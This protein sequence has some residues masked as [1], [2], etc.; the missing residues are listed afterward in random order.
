M[1]RILVRLAGGVLSLGGATLAADVHLGFRG[2]VMTIADAC[3]GV[4][5]AIIYVAAV[6][7]FPGRWRDRILGV[8]IGLPVIFLINLVRVIALMM[9]G[10]VWPEGFHVVHIYVWQGLVVVL[11]LALWAVW[12]ERCLAGGVAAG[13]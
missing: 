5:P 12:A 2:F 4:L 11:A 3:D 7:A 10:A 13:G 8:G 6:L 9:M 1:S